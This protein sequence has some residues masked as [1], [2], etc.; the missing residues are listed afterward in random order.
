M[1][2]SKVA[3]QHYELL[4]ANWLEQQGLS[5]IVRNYRVKFGEIDL[6]MEN[7]EQLVFVEVK[8]RR[9]D[10]YG[11]ALEQVSRK[12]Q[13]RIMRVAQHYLLRYKD[14][15]PCRFDVLAISGTASLQY[16]WIQHAFEV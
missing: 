1:K 9:R 15:R 3:G 12:Q 6:V 5:C 4:A 11:L 7:R 13:L 10:D 2:Q 8:Y 16:N 14:K